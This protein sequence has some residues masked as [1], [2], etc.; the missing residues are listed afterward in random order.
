[1]VGEYRRIFT[2]SEVILREFEGGFG[3]TLVGME[4]R[5]D[6]LETL[7]FSEERLFG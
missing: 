3:G 2:D 6:E 1:L 4:A 5:H 7:C